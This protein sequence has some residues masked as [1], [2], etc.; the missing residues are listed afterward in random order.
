MVLIK[1]MYEY[2]CSVAEVVQISKRNN[3]GLK[4]LQSSV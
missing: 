3:A 1:L 4:K 2:Q